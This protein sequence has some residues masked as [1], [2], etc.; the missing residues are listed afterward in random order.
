VPR[1][2]DSAALDVPCGGGRHSI[3]LAGLGF[4]VVAL[5]NDPEQL[6]KLQRALLATPDLMVRPLLGDATRSLP[7]QDGSFDVV[8]T[9]H[10]VSPLLLAQIPQLLR[11]GGLLIYESFAGHGENWRDLPKRGSI[12]TQ[13]AV[14]FELLDYRERPSGP[15]EADAVVVR[16][17][18]R[19]R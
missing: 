1:A 18:A 7:L 8:V 16:A 5:D 13:L 4:E 14:D 2:A 11:A 3:Y 12:A 6:A 17:A 19:R 15:P 9:T 10:F